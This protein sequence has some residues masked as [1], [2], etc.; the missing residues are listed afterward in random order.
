[1]YKLVIPP[2]K[3]TL[4]ISFDP[5]NHILEFSGSSYPSNPIDFFDPLIDWVASY[6]SETKEQAI[7]VCFKIYYFNTTSSN[8][9]FRILELLNEHN[10]KFQNIKLQW[11]NLDQDDDSLDYWKS[12]MHNLDLPY[13]IIIEPGL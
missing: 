4:G 9:L 2:T 6:L 7:Q 12:L 5:Q 13:E 8:Y 1:M 11:Y 3:T 10:A